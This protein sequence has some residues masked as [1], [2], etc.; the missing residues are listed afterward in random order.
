M[1]VDKSWGLTFYSLWSS[2]WIAC[3]LLQS[4]LSQWAELEEP[5]VS[6]GRPNKQKPWVRKQKERLKAL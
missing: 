1:S 2:Q 5:R 3:Q 6:S 4:W